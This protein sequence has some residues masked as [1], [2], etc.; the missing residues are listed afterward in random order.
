MCNSFQ[1]SSRGIV[2]LT[3]R[4]RTT[5]ICI[6]HQRRTRNRCSFSILSF[7]LLE[8]SQMWINIC[9]FHV[10][11]ICLGPIHTIES[12]VKK[13]RNMKNKSLIFVNFFLLLCNVFSCPYSDKSYI[14]CM[15]PHRKDRQMNELS[16]S[17]IISPT[18]RKRFKFQIR[19]DL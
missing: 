15:W 8:F 19:T 2:H 13:M 5:T 12:V 4:T 6:P 3:Y 14:S 10:L 17:K 1:H 16:T 9:Y 7:H 18:E 11:N